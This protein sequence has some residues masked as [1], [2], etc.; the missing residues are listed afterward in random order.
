MAAAPPDS[1]TFLAAGLVFQKARRHAQA[2]ACFRRALEGWDA[3]AQQG[4]DR[5]LAVKAW[6]SLSQSCLALDD[7]AG[8]IE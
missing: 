6:W 2:S 5:A 7:D 1:A 3:D 4:K 8:G